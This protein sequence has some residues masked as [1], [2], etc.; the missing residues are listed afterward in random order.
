MSMA[1]RHDRSI[2]DLTSAHEVRSHGHESPPPRARAVSRRITRSDAL[3]LRHATGYSQ[4]TEASVRAEAHLLPESAPH[5]GQ[6]GLPSSSW[7]DAMVS[8]GLVTPSPQNDLCELRA[9]PHSELSIDA[10]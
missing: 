10:G 9:A 4:D 1:R 7:A 6:H 8:L 2:S 3:H 5:G